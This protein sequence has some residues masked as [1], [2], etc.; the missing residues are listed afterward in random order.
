M[1]NIKLDPE[2]SLTSD[3]H[4]WILE[5]KG[6]AQHFYT[7]LD[8]AISCYFGMKVRGSDAKTISGLVEY[9]KRCIE[10]LCK[11]LTPLQIKVIPLKTSGGLN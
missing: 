10:A 8:N 6:Y 7:E 9:H 5:K 4:Q 3:K 11:V 1:V 2:W